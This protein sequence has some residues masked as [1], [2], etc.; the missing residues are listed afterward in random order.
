[1]SKSKKSKVGAR[2]VKPK[3]IN[4]KMIDSITFEYK[5]SEDYKVYAV[6]GL[7][8]GITPK[9]D[10]MINLFY[11]GNPIPEHSTYNVNPDGSIGDETERIVSSSLVRNIPFGVSMA[12]DTAKSFKGWLEDKIEKHDAIFIQNQEKEE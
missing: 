5:L 1:M 6:N 3:E 8:G 12:I 11:E 10:L 4:N 7:F 2:L 9:G